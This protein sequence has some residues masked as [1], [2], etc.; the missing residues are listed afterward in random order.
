[1][2]LPHLATLAIDGEE[3]RLFYTTSALIALLLGLTWS[4]PRGAGRRSTLPAIGGVFMVA[5]LAAQS[6]LLRAAV[7]PWTDAGEQAT[8]LVRALPGLAQTIPDS[9]YGLVLVADHLGAVPFGR[10]AQG[11][12]ISPPTQAA[13][14]SARLV[15][16]TPEE[17]SAWPSHISR[18]LVD[19]LRRYPLA[20]AWPAVEAGRASAA[21]APSDFFCWDSSRRALLPLRLPANAASGEWIAAWRAALM[22]SACREL[23]RDL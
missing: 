15:V 20:Q 7:A 19:A 5:M 21:I 12:L 8:A 1:M 23:A 17:L 3:G 9:G 10:N 6:V 16:Q 4:M 14:L 2:V 11:G 22:A 18:G 13:P